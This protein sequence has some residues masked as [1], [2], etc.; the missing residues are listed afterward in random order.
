MIKDS[1]GFAQ[2]IGARMRIIRKQLGHSGPEMASVLSIDRTAYYKNESGRNFP[3]TLTL[4]RLQKNFDI[5]MDWLIFNKGP[6]IFKNKKQEEKKPG[7]LEQTPEV[8]KL[9]EAMEQDSQLK[10]EMLSQFYKYQGKKK[11]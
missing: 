1:G 3:G 9:L 6:M 10:F 2:N 11:S 8:K 4:Y 7:L 5:S